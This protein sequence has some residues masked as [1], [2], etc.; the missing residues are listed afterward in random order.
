MPQPVVEARKYPY[1]PSEN[2]FDG[3]K[4]PRW[5]PWSTSCRNGAEATTTAGRAKSAP[6]SRDCTSSTVL[7]QQDM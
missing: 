4:K 7:N 6:P 5:R 3:L 2:T 1:R